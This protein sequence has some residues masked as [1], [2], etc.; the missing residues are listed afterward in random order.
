MI[1]WTQLNNGKAKWQL[2]DWKILS[3]SFWDQ[4]ENQLNSSE[5]LPGFT[6]LQILHII[7][8]LE[9]AHIE[10]EEFS[11]R[12]IFMSMFNDI[13]VDRRGNDAS[14]TL[15]SVKIQEY[16]SRFMEG[17]W[18]FLGPGGEKTVVSWV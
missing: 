4:M 1:Q 8:E 13:I 6:A 17:H 5:I 7:S 12:I 16:A 3:V 18:A 9:E 15:T 11:D 2:F 14:C 10:P